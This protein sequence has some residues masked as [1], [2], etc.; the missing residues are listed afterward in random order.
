MSQALHEIQFSWRW[1]GL[2]LHCS[3]YRKD[4]GRPWCFQ[5]KAFQEGL[6]DSSTG[7]RHMY[8]KLQPEKVLEAWLCSSVICAW[9]PCTSGRVKEERFVISILSKAAADTGASSP[10]K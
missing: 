5:P 7:E 4:K 2:A 10:C 9:K 8:T 3:T 6:N 1:P